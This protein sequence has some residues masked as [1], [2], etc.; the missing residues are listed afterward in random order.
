[1]PLMLPCYSKQ[2][3]IGA[4]LRPSVCL[5]TIDREAIYMYFKIWMDTKV[6]VQ[7]KF[8]HVLKL[9][10]FIPNARERWHL[11]REEKNHSTARLQHRRQREQD[12]RRS[13]QTEVRRARLGRWRICGHKRRAAEQPVA[14]QTRLDAKNTAANNVKLKMQFC[15]MKRT[16]FPSA[17]LACHAWILHIVNAAACS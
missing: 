7:F 1:M 11:E 2:C 14:T 9:M 8:T 16:S 15:S 3:L 17:S 10:F 4:S 6:H 13:E 5:L 12:R